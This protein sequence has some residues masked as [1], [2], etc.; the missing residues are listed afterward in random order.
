M[1]N[2][3]S[4]PWVRFGLPLGLCLAAL[5]SIPSHAAP[6]QETAAAL[7]AEIK[8]ARDDVDPQKIR[9]LAALKSRDAMNGLVELYGVMAS[10]YMRLEI[11]RTLPVF[12]GVPDAEQ[13]ALQKLMDIATSAKEPELRDGAVAALGSCK[14]LGKHFLQLIVDSPAEDAVREN[15]M[16]AHV[17]MAAEADYP[18]YVK[19]FEFG[20]AGKADK[21][22]K[23]GKDEEPELAVHPLPRVR[24][25]AMG[26]VAAKLE[27]KVLVATA[28]DMEKDP[29]D[30]RKDGLRRIA[31]TELARRK[32]RDAVSVAGD[33]YKNV[34]EKSL[35]RILAAQILFAEQG[36]KIAST[37]IED[38]DKPTTQLDLALAT[39]DMIAGLKDPAI[40]GK[41][42][43]LVGKDKGQGQLFALR[44]TRN[45][46]DEK[47]DK[48]I[49]KLL[50][51][52]DRDVSRAAARALGERGVKLAVPELEAL[53][54]K[55]KDA[56]FVSAA[57]DALGA[58]HGED[59]AW[60]QK[61]LGFT[62]HE[63]LEVRVAA[64]EQLAKQ[65]DVPELLK[66]LDSPDW[67]TRLAALKGLESV[68]TAEIVGTLIQRMQKEEGRMLVEFGQTLWRL[69][70]EPFYTQSLA[71][72]GWWEK[73]SKGFQ[74]IGA[75]ELAKREADEAARR[76]KQVS[77]AS[78][79][80]IRIKSRRV[81]FI[82]DVSG[83]MNELTRGEYVGK[84]GEPRINV[85]KR[86]LT[87]CIDALEQ[88]SLFN[89]VVFS[90]DVEKWLP[91]GISDAK[92]TNREDAKSYVEKLGANGGTNLY[93][94]LREAFADQ[95]V[96]TIFVLSDGEPSVGE[97]IDPGTIREHVR[98][99]NE[100]RKITINSIAVGG[101]FEILRW[102]A[103]D[104]GGIHVEFP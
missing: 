66:A 74:P 102:L 40:D 13:P 14:N 4:G 17:A 20:T 70:G 60:R 39:A 41:V 48:A 62:T 31:L 54:L 36:A 104:T 6:P 53:L 52:E 93:G 82:L 75:E 56:L 15:A 5:F 22:K 71:W 26:Q 80:G 44:A 46:K 76:L 100:H 49:L 59:P 81:I 73:N 101:T 21:K 37:F 96:D 23:P 58:I 9:D 45:V 97:V 77:R 65:K 42:V 3:S 7:V 25:L 69:S 8:K 19:E 43:R 29:S 30:L 1:K 84:Q 89:V 88:D 64:V 33:V 28:K 35:N 91:E 24:E 99:W 68:R 16:R 34:S 103:E 10:I 50:V 55:S 95:D 32:T 83:S 98:A 61:L 92:G 2:S 78:F 94:S 85:A 72:K 38:A 63:K 79:F 86:E 87:K 18:W 12:D 11:L 67:S 47:L 57:V 51:S 90:S 27:V